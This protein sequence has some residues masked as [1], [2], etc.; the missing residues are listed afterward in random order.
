[1]IRRVDSHVTMQKVIPGVNDRYRALWEVPEEHRSLGLISCDIEDVMDFALDDASRKAQI[2]V[3][4]VETVY[5]GADYSWS[6]YGG[7]ITAV[8][9]GPRVEDVRSG[10]MYTRDYIEHKCGSYIINEDASM[11]YFVDFLPRAGLYNQERFGLPEG[12]ALA[13]LVAPPVEATYALDKA[14]KASNTRILEFYEAPTRVN[15]G[16]ALLCGTEAACRSA[17]EAFRDAVAYCYAHPM[18][19]DS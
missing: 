6:R 12:T 16:G 3:L 7:E 19:L 9:S 4:H 11:S 15:T 5:G 2:K 1:M 14:L 13:K 17:V 18:L 10:L 8:I